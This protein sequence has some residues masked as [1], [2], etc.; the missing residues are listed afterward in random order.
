MSDGIIGVS[1]GGAHTGIV[2]QDRLV[3]AGTEAVGDIV[4]ASRNGNQ[5]DFRLTRTVDGEQIATDKDG[6]WFEQSTSIGNTFV[7]MLQRDGLF[8]FGDRAEARIAEG[9]F[10]ASTVR[11][12]ESSWYGSET[13]KDPVI[14]DANVIFLQAGAKDV[15]LFHWTEAADQYEAHSL[16]V[17]AGD[18]FKRAID[19]VFVRSGDEQGDTLYILDE[20]GH[21]AVCVLR[22]T[23]PNVAWSIWKFDG[24]K[25]HA[26]G[27][28]NGQLLVAAERNGILKLETVL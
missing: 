14:V 9:A 10:T 20:D 3:L 24:V 6:F 28:L 13:G 8:M 26:L 4:L 11:I 19:M 16:R 2:Y 22:K 21:I 1:Y 12:E 7:A 25:I 18:V 23:P 15:R 17:M 27:E 5:V